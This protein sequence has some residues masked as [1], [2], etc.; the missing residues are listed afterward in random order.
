MARAGGVRVGGLAVID[1]AYTVDI[2]DF[3]LPMWQAGIGGYAFGNCRFRHAEGAGHGGCGGGVLG[4]MRA[5]QRARARHVEIF[6]GDLHHLRRLRF[7]PGGHVARKIVVNADDRRAVGILAIENMALGGDVAG[8]VAVAVQVVGR[9]IQHGCD[10]EAE[11]GDSL[12]HVAGHFKHVDAVIRQQRQGQRSWAEIGAG[13]MRHAS[14]RQ[15]VRE[16]R[17]RRRLAVGAGDA[18]EFG[19][20][21]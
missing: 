6:A 17:G 20:A 9:K 14:D 5:R 10:I 8:H 21:A 16:Q 15:D 12:Q 7:E 3:G 4:V 1:E 18:G 19:G 13:R 2:G 11:G